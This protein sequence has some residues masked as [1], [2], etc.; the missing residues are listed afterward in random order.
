MVWQSSEN[1]NGGAKQIEKYCTHMGRKAGKDCA[2][3]TNVGGIM[4][5][6]GR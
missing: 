6:P 1:V 5:K 4:K 3:T 2:Y